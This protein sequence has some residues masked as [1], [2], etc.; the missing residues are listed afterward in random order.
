MRPTGARIRLVKYTPWTVVVQVNN[1]YTNFRIPPDPIVV[2]RLSVY[3]EKAQ[4]EEIF[5]LVK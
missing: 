5:I 1:G 4:N 2:R 3:E